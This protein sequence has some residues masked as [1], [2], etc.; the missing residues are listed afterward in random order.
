MLANNNNIKYF[1]IFTT[2]FGMKAPL[3]ERCERLDES[4]QILGVMHYSRWC[5]EDKNKP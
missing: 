3:V 2:A 5:E 1:Y 4:G